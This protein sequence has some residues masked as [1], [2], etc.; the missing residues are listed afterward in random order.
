MSHE[1]TEPLTPK[2]PDGFEVDEDVAFQQRDWKFERVGWIAIALIVVAAMAGLF[3]RGGVSDAVAETTDGTLRVEYGRL[4]R[5]RAPSELTVHVRPRAGDTSVTIAINDDFL[6]AVRVE[7]LVPEPESQ[8]SIVEHTLYTLPT[9]PG[10]SRV[11]LTLYFVPD[12][13]GKRRLTI[14]VPGRDSVQLG[15]FVFP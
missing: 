15:L 5:H 2:R 14:T 1:S 11:R 7:Q 12:D 13:I 6:R 8:R 10:S 3:G 4:M 9:G